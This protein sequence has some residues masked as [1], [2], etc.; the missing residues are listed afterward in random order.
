MSSA[1]GAA[2]ETEQ[3]VVAVA[4]VETKEQYQTPATTAA[5][6][7]EESLQPELGQQIGWA[8]AYT[9]HPLDLVPTLFFSPPPLSALSL[10]FFLSKFLLNG[11][12]L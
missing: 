6:V 2:L 4:E 12:G 9:L 8:P 3:P 10:S 7:P 5:V 1:S 11:C